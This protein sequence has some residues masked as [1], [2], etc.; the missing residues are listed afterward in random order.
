M[1][2]SFPK[3]RQDN[4]A[5]TAAGGAEE[6][7]RAADGL[8]VRIQTLTRVVESLP[9]VVYVIGEKDDT[10]RYVNDFLGTLLRLADTDDRASH[11][12]WLEHLHPD[13]RERVLA[14]RAACRASGA[15]FAADYRLTA[16]DGGVIWVSDHAREMD[17][18]DTGAR[19]RVGVLKDITLRREADLALRQ[20]L[21]LNAALLAT[22][23]DFVAYLD[24]D[25]RVR[26]LSVS[27]AEALGSTVA[28][29]V[30]VPFSALL[31]DVDVPL[32]AW[33]ERCRDGALQRHDV[34]LALP[35]AGQRC[36]DVRLI[37]YEVR[38]ALDGILFLGRD[39]TDAVLQRAALE[40]REAQVRNIAANVP[41]AIFRYIERPDGQSRMRYMSEGCSGI[42][43]VE[44][45]DVEQDAAVLWDMVLPEDRPAM[46]ESVQR[47]A[48]EL[49]DWEHQWRVRTPSG[50][51][52]WLHGRGKPQRGSDGATI[53]DSVVLDESARKR[54]ELE[55]DRL[56]HQDHLTLLPNRLAFQ[57]RL[58]DAL[59][60]NAE[61]R[62]LVAL[63]FID[64][65]NFKQ[66]NDSFGHSAGDRLLVELARVLLGCIPPEQTLARISG[67]ELG[68]ITERAQDQQGVAALARSLLAAVE[69]WRFHVEE[70]EIAV[71]I[72]IGIS[73]APL[74]AQDAETML[75]TAD[76]AMY[77]AKQLGRNRYQFYDPSFTEAVQQRIAFENGLRRALQEDGLVLHYQPQVA[78]TDGRILGV[79]ALLRWRHPE[80]GIL[81]PVAFLS[82]AEGAG[83]MG[84]IGEWV[85]AQAFA[86]FADWKRAGIAPARL[87]LNVSAKQ[88][89][90]ADFPRLVQT[91]LRRF[92]LAPTEVELEL[93]EDLLVEEGGE[94]LRVLQ[95][96][97][98]LGLGMA[99]DDFGTGRSSL[100]Y[101]R[102]LPLTR[103][104]IDPSFIA[105]LPDADAAAIVRSIVSLAGSLGLEVIA[106][107]VETRGQA[108]FLLANGCPAVQGFYFTEPKSAGEVMPLLAAGRI[109]PAVVATG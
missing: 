58:A 53:W 17:A 88:V 81:R 43:E 48:R 68:V 105:A 8:L 1:K 98:G 106:E 35:A 12:L 56:A 45:A 63:L 41:G 22:V 94:S 21:G 10:P 47:S 30:G 89:A 92:A 50:R 66:V 76:T 79:E 64:V 65:D 100:A 33:I 103:I 34:W 55:L 109:E 39:V 29:A 18:E 23:P 4:A 51:L 5:G 104:K 61:R 96:L 13:D 62:G 102:R 86:T 71:S 3:H 25:L 9:M 24:P 83:I 2:R 77:R 37:P 99:I 31:A 90:D 93:S 57:R 38:G 52:K 44:V 49:T 32:A 54:A 16:D 101:L 82:I 78:V 91:M 26:H 107:G 11:S 46:R 36:L 20:S 74:D 108:E 95:A 73:L 14:E 75:Q 87:A 60:R 97:A 6:L 28:E 40:E 19:V 42:W 72:S 84:P 7:S 59:A 80:Q 27:L 67:D 70:Q 15:P 85:L 69:Q